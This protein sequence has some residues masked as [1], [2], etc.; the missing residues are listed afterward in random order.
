M[1]K[2]V[3]ILG[4]IGN[5]SILEELEKAGYNHV[6]GINPLSGPDNKPEYLLVNIRGEDG[7]TDII[8]L[9]K[10]YPEARIVVL[11]PYFRALAAAMNVSPEDA[12]NYLKKER[13]HYLEKPVNSDNLRDA[14]DS[15]Q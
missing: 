4:Q 10:R 8:G 14:F 3:H 15:L 6:V 5:R 9:R 12:M 11:H 7:D 1:P 2:T 13:I